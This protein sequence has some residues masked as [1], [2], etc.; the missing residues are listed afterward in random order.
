MDKLEQDYANSID[1]K[2]DKIEKH[3]LELRTEQAKTN[4]YLSQIVTALAKK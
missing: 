4:A 3:L 2:L 1:R